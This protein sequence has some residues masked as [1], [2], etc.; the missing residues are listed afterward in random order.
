MSVVLLALMSTVS[1]TVPTVPAAA[2]RWHA[3][4]APRLFPAAV[5]GTSP[6][7]ARVT[8]LLAG[9][10]RE[11]PCRQ[12]F[13]PAA[14]RLLRGCVTVLRATYAD[15]TQTYVVTAAVTVLAGPA[16]AG[17]TAGIPPGTTVAVRAKRT[18]ALVRPLAVAGGP[19]E[20]FGWR[21]CFTGFAVASGDGRVVATSA[22]YADGR[23][24]RRGWPVVPRLALG[25]RQLAEAL[26]RNLA[27]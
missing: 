25:A 9:A 11:T 3:S 23:P 18:R 14:L 13:R 15:S 24:Y 6:S 20:R 27:R 7:G 22:G 16:T 17:V 2:E 1:P 8:Y 4:P 21:Q 5:P 10:P 12:A 26:H 19:A